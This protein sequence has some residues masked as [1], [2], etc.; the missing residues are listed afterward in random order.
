M[1]N[2]QDDP[3]LAAM[4]ARSGKTPWGRVLLGV[5]VVGCGTFGL[6]Y[7]LP[8][9]RAHKTLADDHAR[10]RTELE[11]VQQKLTKAETELKD[12]TAKRDELDEQVKKQE[13]KSSG[14]ASDAASLKGALETAVDKLAKKKLA[15]VGTDATGARVA[16]AAGALFA[17]GK[18]EVSGGGASTLCAVAKAAGN[19]SLRVIGI[20]TDDDVPAALKSK[21]ASAWGYTSAAAGEVA[22][23]LHEKCNVAGT[24]LYAEGSDGTRAT[25]AAF[26]G[27]KPPVPRIE[28]LITTEAKP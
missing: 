2:W 23:T 13:A 12:A 3:D 6:A 20:A 15:A 14:A 27:D 21:F 18:L 28:L 19:R 8:L 4:R 7:Y 5:L 17:S 16:L 1:A 26:S 22:A 11:G 9:Y 24:K 10:L 25:S